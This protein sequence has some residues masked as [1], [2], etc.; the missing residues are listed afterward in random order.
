[1]ANTHRYP[2]LHFAP[3]TDY[4]HVNDVLLRQLNALGRKLGKVITVISGYRTKAQQ[5]AL[6][7][8]YI[9]SGKDRRYIAAPP[10]HSKH[11]FGLAVDATIGG[12]A[13]GKVVSGKLLAQ[14]GLSTPV[15]GDYPHVQL[16]DDKT[17]AA[18]AP[19]AGA[20]TAQAQPTGPATS[21]IELPDY[22][23]PLPLREAGSGPPDALLPGT[24]PAQEFSPRMLQETWRLIASQPGA[25]QDTLSYASLV[26]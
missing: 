15:R 16:L 23:G 7:D 6:Y 25:H 19:S 1:V 13:I 20:A 2:F 4:K 21:G 22:G 12:V 10:G 26:G 18:A 17:A 8:R 3:G 9:K 11:E 5:A 14:F 24:S